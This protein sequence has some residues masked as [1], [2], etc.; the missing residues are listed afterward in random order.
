MASVSAGKSAN[1]STVSLRYL[2]RFDALV[3]FDRR[4]ALSEIDSWHRQDSYIY[5]R[6]LLR[7]ICKGSL[8]T[9]AAA[10]R[11]ILS[12]SQQTFWDLAHR[13]DFIH[14]LISCW[15]SLSIHS[16]GKLLKRIVK[17]RDR[18]EGESDDDYNWRKAET[19]LDMI[20]FLTMNG[21]SIDV[22]ISKAIQ[23]LKGYCHEWTPKSAVEFDKPAWVYVGPQETLTDHNIL[24]DVPINEVVDT[25]ERY[26]NNNKHPLQDVDMFKGLCDDNPG[27]AIAALRS[28]AKISEYPEWAWCTLLRANWEKGVS[29]RY[30]HRTTAMLCK[31]TDQQLEEMKHFIFGWFSDVAD[32]YRPKSIG[33]RDFLFRRL[34]GVIRTNPDIDYYTNDEREIGSI[35]WVS[36]SL[37]SKTGRLV[38][39]L[40]G[41]SEYRKHSGKALPRSWLDF[42]ASLLSLDGN[43]GRFALVSLMLHLAYLY[44][45]APQWT[46]DLILRASSEEDVLTHDAYWEGFVASGPLGK[47][48]YLE[49]KEKLIE[50]LELDSLVSGDVIEGLSAILLGAWVGEMNDD[51]SLL[52]DGEYS[53]VLVNGSEQLRV[54]F[55]EQLW[56]WATDERAACD[57][58]RI[59]KIE[60]LIMDIWPLNEAAIS[61]QTN[62]YLL[63]IMFLNESIFSKFYPIAINRFGEIKRFDIF[64]RELDDEYKTI[65]KKHPVQLLDIL[66]RTFPRKPGPFMRDIEKIAS[67]LANIDDACDEIESD[68]RYWELW[69]R[70]NGFG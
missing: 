61:E 11:T 4:R 58:D 8:L 27:M 69:N 24:Y 38:A 16:Q 63:K 3:E 68:G 18:F 29:N 41:F 32:K 34:V 14:T 35:D 51:G 53:D 30:L 5:D 20:E 52:T 22:D 43:S 19:S 10:S 57:P 2:R 64:L 62:L 28:K 1:Y 21:C 70:V 48:L 46:K 42:A 65:M 60:R 37:N 13:Y 54:S 33:L 66:H 17:G 7:A 45:R 40:Q 15:N 39:A 26:M 25:A 23:K 6:F 67:I 47:C 36:K 31:A 59:K 56:H 50:K 44:G 55:L 49:V 12:L 9:P